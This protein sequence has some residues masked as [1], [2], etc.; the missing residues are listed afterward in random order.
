MSREAKRVIPS[1]ADRTGTAQPFGHAGRWWNSRGHS[2][3]R[4]SLLRCAADKRTRSRRPRLERAF[5]RQ[6]SREIRHRWQDVSVQQY[7]DLLRRILDEGVEWPAARC[8]E[9]GGGVAA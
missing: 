8:S 7:L 5:G 9:F 4:R 2:R 1:R 3:H 6:V